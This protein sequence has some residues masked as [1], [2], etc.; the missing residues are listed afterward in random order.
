MLH[1]DANDMKNMCRVS[2][3][4]KQ[5][6]QSEK[7]WKEKRGIH[8]PQFVD[9]YAQKDLYSARELEVVKRYYANKS[10]EPEQLTN[11]QKYVRIAKKVALFKQWCETDSLFREWMIKIA[12]LLKTHGAA[13]FDEHDD[14][15][16]SFKIINI[17]HY[18]RSNGT[19]NVSDDV[20]NY[21]HIHPIGWCHP[22]G[23]LSVCK[24]P[25]Y[26][27]SNNQLSLT[28]C[29]TGTN[30][31]QD[32][33]IQLSQHEILTQARFDNK[34]EYTIQLSVDEFCFLTN[35]RPASG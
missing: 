15:I 26:I 35:S 4:T 13:Y 12:T 8:F 10:V 25:L 6:G 14:Q 5:I 33:N 9:N 18:Y 16:K 7:F 20:K 1:V 24:N 23:L 17:C 3:A 30:L 2:R 21:N 11:K 22:G 29:A 27:N 19:L 28:P 34:S 31:Y 32:E